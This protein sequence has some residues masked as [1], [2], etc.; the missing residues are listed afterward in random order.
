MK[1]FTHKVFIAIIGMILLIVGAILYFVNWHTSQIAEKEIAKRLEQSYKVFQNYEREVTTSL[2]QVNF[3]ITGN[4]SYRAYMA[5]SLDHDDHQSI[6][7]QFDEIRRFANCDFMIVFD[8]DRAMVVDT[9]QTIATEAEEALA[10]YMDAVDN[11]SIPIGPLRSGNKLF[12][13]VMS[14]LEEEE[15]ILGYVLVGYAMD[16][17]TA[18]GIGDIANCDI[19]L[20][21]A[22][23]G[24]G[25]TLVAS[26]FEEGGNYFDH[27]LVAAQAGA[28][29]GAVFDFQIRGQPY[30]GLLGF[31]K[32]ADQTVV[33]RYVTV[34]S[35]KRELAPFTRITHGLMFIGLVAMVWGRCRRK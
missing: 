30:K 23:E 15:Y 16:D 19:L 12:T 21:T 11:G 32:A 18:M 17:Q 35:V 6:L 28:K 7:D 13:V 4:A 29:E 14:P 25:A 5:A 20:L 31:M 26:Y 33:G 3:Y 8:A 2:R 27:D 24:D 1:S 10:G 34:K 9:T 22:D